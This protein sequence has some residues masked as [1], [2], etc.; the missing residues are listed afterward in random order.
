[1]VGPPESESTPLGPD[2]AAILLR[3]RLRAGDSLSAAAREVAKETRLPRSEL[4]RIAM[5]VQADIK[6]VK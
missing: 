1:M 3:E 5:E 6:D 4:Y 2:A